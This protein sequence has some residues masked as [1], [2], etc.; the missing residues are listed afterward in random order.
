MTT[1]SLESSPHGTGRSRDRRSES[2]EAGV[3]AKAHAELVRKVRHLRE[4]L[5]DT[6]SKLDHSRR[7]VDE[8]REQVNRLGSFDSVNRRLRTLEQGL[9]HLEGQLD[10]VMRMQMPAARPYYSAQAP[11]YQQGPGPGMA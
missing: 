6:Q 2:E 11:P 4:D 3:S 9:S 5:A 10:V 1:S 8:L 7:E